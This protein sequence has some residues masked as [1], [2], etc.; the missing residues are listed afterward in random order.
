MHCTADGSYFPI[1]GA[2]TRTPLPPA[3][4]TLTV[5]AG[6]L[7]PTAGGGAPLPAGA[8]TPG[9]HMLVGGDSHG[10]PVLAVS[11]VTAMGLYHP[12]TVAGKLL[13]DGAVVATDRVTAVPP[14]AAAVVLAAARAAATVGLGGVLS[15]ALAFGCPPPLR[16]VLPL[17]RALS[18]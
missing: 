9:V 18:G 6:Y 13:I 15:R 7:L 1:H 10:R 3:L 12:Y 14:A 2:A 4:H 8:I 16:A 11:A 17:L 5:T